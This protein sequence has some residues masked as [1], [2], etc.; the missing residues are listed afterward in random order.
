[1]GYN[2]AQAR[3]MKAPWESRTECRKCTAPILVQLDSGSSD[4][5]GLA[6]F[7]CPACGERQQAEH[8]AG[9][10]PLSVRAAQATD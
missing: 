3:Q 4:A 6:I 1:M 7:Y 10:D 8:P 9:Y 2:E 5:P